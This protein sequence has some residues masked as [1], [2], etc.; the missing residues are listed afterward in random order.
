MEKI[1]EIQYE[2]KFGS[3]ID[4]DAIVEYAE[5]YDLEEGKVTK[6]ILCVYLP[7][8]VSADQQAAVK[9]QAVEQFHNIK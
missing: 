7:E 9:A 2:G 3:L 1:V 8:G 4:A 6:E 5:L